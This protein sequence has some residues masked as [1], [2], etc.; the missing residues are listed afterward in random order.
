LI[1]ELASDNYRWQMIAPQELLF[2]LDELHPDLLL[3]DTRQ[4]EPSA[5]DISRLFQASEHQREID[6]IAVCEEREIEELYSAGFMLCLSIKTLD[7]AI[8]RQI[9]RRWLRIQQR[10][11]ELSHLRESLEK[12]SQVMRQQRQNYAVFA[13]TLSHEIRTPLGIIE[14]FAT[15]LLDGLDGELSASQQQSLNIIHSNIQRLKQYL[16]DILDHSKLEVEEIR[17]PKTSPSQE[18]QRRVFRRRLLPLDELIAEVVAMFSESLRRKDLILQLDISPN[19]PRLWM[20]HSKIRQVFVNLLSNACKYTPQGGQISIKTQNL[21]D[22]QCQIST[23]TTNRRISCVQIYI[24]DNG[25]GIP[26]EALPHLFEQ[27]VRVDGEEQQSEGS[28]LGLA[29]CKQII[30]EHGGDIAVESELGRGTSM[31]VTLPVDLRRR[32]SGRLFVL[33]QAE[34]LLELVEE[35]IHNF[36]EIKQ[37]K[38]A[39]QLHEVFNSGIP[40]I[41]VVSD[42][43]I[44]HNLCA[45]WN[46]A[47]KTNSKV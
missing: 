3:F 15:N 8:L 16:G 4:L 29:I 46:N 37:I 21:G 44:N 27:F 47:S 28:G 31:S 26:Q 14:G 17:S 42:T 18:I 32:R 25:P 34:T 43:I 39:S 45:V 19:L 2:R 24:I 5:A 30:T 9:L 38:E 22:N 23:T 20:D 7:A 12:Q 10:E 6:L 1:A 11:A 35:N 41:I 36:D 13:G 40:D 33:E